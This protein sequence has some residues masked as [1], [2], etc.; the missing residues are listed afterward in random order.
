M[1]RPKRSNLQVIEDGFADLSL[2]EQSIMLETLAQ[3]HRWCKRERS[4]PTPEPYRSDNPALPLPLPS[5]R[6]ESLP[7][8]SFEDGLAVGRKLLYQE[9][10]Q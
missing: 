7:M 9:H 10:E 6:G 1:A 2:N 5:E 8:P 3:L 4:R